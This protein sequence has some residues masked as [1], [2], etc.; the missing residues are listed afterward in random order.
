MKTQEKI[1]VIGQKVRICDDCNFAKGIIGK[2]AYPPK[3]SFLTEEFGDNCFRRMTTPKGEIIFVWII[4]DN[5]Q[6]DS[7]GDGNYNE[8]EINIKYLEAI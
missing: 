7:E 5:P 4:F 1:F 6:L 2:V 8:A 3:V